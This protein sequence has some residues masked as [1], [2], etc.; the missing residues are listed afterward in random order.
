MGNVLTEQ[1]LQHRFFGGG[2]EGIRAVMAV[3]R[4][5]RD[6]DGEFDVFSLLRDGGMEVKVRTRLT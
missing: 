3:E 5:E 2:E 6:A 1:V 4:D